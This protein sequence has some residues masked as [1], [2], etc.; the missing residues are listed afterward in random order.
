MPKS[1]HLKSLLALV[2]AMAMSAAPLLA[3]HKPGATPKPPVAAVSEAG[4]SFDSLL[5]AD[6]Y[7]VYC[8]IRG[9]GGLIHSPA[10]SDLLDP[11]IKLGKPPKEFKSIVKWLNAHAEVLG[12]SRLMVAG[13]PSRPNLP[14]VLVAVEFSSPE[15]AKK[16]YPEL[17]DFLPTLLPTPTPSPTP[18]PSPSPSGQP[19]A[20]AR[21]DSAI[22]YQVRVQSIPPASQ[23]NPVPAPP[24]YQMSQAGSLVFISDTAF[25]IRDLKPRGSK[26]LEEDQNFVLARNR[27][28][29]ESIFLYVDLQA[30]QKEERE[31]WKK[32]E[33][34]DEKRREAAAALPSPTEEPSEMTKS[35][36]ASPESEASEED[37]VD[38]EMPP[39]EATGETGTGEPP[40]TGTLSGSP[41]PLDDFN[42][43]ALMLLGGLGRPAGEKWPEAIA[44]AAV[45]EG[46][47]YVARVLLL[48]GA[49]NNANA[50]PFFPQFVPGPAIVPAAPNVLPADADLFVTASVDYLQI[51]DK[52]LPIFS[53]ASAMSTRDDQTTNR[54]APESPFAAYENKLGMKLRGDLLPLLGSELAF[55]LPRSPEQEQKDTAPQPSDSSTPPPETSG[56]PVNSDPNPIVA[57]SI[58]DREAVA[59]VLPKIIEAFGVKGA[60]QFAQTERRGSTEIVSYA[61]VFSYAFIE[62]F[63]VIS[64]EPKEVRHAVDAYLNNETLSANGHFKNFTRWQ[65]RQVLGQ[66]YVAPSLVEQFTL[67]N[68]AAFS[69]KMREWLS[70]MNPVIDPLTYSLTT[71]GVGHLHE[72]HVPK[73][74]LQLLIAKASSAAGDVPLQA[75]ERM[76]ES[77]LRTLH[78]AEATFQATEGNGNYGT[79]EEL[80]SAQLLAR[81]SME[82]NGYRFECTAAKDKFVATAVPIDY[83]TTGRLSFFI[84]E[85]GV[86]RAGDKGGGAA[87]V[88]DQALN[89]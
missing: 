14:T 15:E 81:E 20:A 35:A 76:A 61:G 40:P 10:V 74:L 63:L 72:F 77:L 8:E 85:S 52:L 43:F 13:W 59:K 64:P 3:Q 9:V 39:P 78:S 2:L 55:A 67:G 41:P 48:N 54:P 53:G 25:A 4:P 16:F 75:N 44:V 56:A 58:K 29:S 80:M 88:A 36:E 19:A 18:S 24:P 71:D 27:F 51:Y 50:I 34:E 38:Q 6:T 84:D 42:P 65:P 62:N 28:A 69:E 12:G 45:F 17:R 79:L 1:K 70:R 23:D 7:K 68:K 47:A 83:G 82:R 30:I 32:L 46:D 26:P 60:G 89:R 37:S 66:V 87:T 22:Q 57:I 11:L 33:E 73:N 49:E 21:S 86:L 5:A 31:Q